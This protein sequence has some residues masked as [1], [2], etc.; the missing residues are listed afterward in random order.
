MDKRQI[1]GFLR[2]LELISNRYGIAIEVGHPNVGGVELVSIGSSKR[3]R[4]DYES[5]E[6]GTRA[7]LAT[8][9]DDYK[10]PVVARPPVRIGIPVYVPAESMEGKVVAI[11]GGECWINLD[12]DPPRRIRAKISDLRSVEQ[13]E[14][15]DRLRGTLVRSIEYP[16]EL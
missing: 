16:E 8:Y 13:T 5:I 11:N 3:A 15:L 1:K 10:N 12:C 6:P 7:H 14:E 4:Y 2:E 9:I